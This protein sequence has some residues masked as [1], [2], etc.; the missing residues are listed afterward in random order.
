[1]TLSRLSNNTRLA[2]TSLFPLA[3]KNNLHSEH[4]RLRATPRTVAKLQK[5]RV[6]TAQSLPEK[7][8]GSSKLATWLYLERNVNGASTPRP[9]NPMATY[10]EMDPRFKPNSAQVYFDAP[11][12]RIDG[13]Q[14]LVY[15]TDTVDPRIAAA[16]LQG[17][18][19]LLAVHPQIC[20]DL[21]VPFMSEIA[22][23]PVQKMLKV[24]ATASS[25]TV[26]VQDERVPA[27]CVKLHFPKKITRSTRHLEKRK[28]EHSIA[29]SN[30]LASSV[31]LRNNKWFGYLPES[32]G[33]VYGNDTNS[34]G[35][36]V[37]EMTPRP[38]IAEDR[39]LMPLFSLYSPDLNNPEARP[40]LCSLIE[41]SNLAPEVFILEKI[42]YPLLSSWADVFQERGIL[43][44]AHGQNTCLELDESGMPQ[45][46]IFRDLDTHVN[47]DIRLKK[48]LSLEGMNP[49]EVYDNKDSDQGPQGCV[50]SLLYDQAMKVP[51]DS[52]AKLAEKEYGIPKERLQQKCRSYL[53]QVFPQG[54]LYFPKGGKVF[55]Y[56][57]SLAVGAKAELVETSDTPAWR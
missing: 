35:F 34:W 10:S 29:L 46:M 16:Y 31:A 8:K 2:R 41:N 40:L 9:N 50:M 13:M 45:R 19:A 28:I 27:H 6:K 47:R 54:D 1:M 12:Y 5:E 21:E 37:R 56:K 57:G 55:N 48:G 51:F 4:S 53:R 20:E 32:F 24:S 25:R 7:S 18:D 15:R 49:F 36:L 17:Q 39:Q 11:C 43:I 52:I 26:F 33:V 42:F 14:A 3:R 44:E 38:F 30:D 22:S 23:F